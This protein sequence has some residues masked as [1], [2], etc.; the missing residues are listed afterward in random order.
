[1]YIYFYYNE[2]KLLSTE[3]DDLVT[4]RLIDKNRS[5]IKAQ[6][7]FPVVE[8]TCIGAYIKRHHHTVNIISH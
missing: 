2:Y 5:V 7:D 4:L 3:V 8:E 1:M 6:D